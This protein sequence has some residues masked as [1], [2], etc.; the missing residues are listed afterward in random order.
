MDDGRSG[1]RS[2]FCCSAHFCCTLQ[3]VCMP[4]MMNDHKPEEICRDFLRKACSRGSSCKFRH[5][6][7]SEKK[8]EFCRDFQNSYCHRVNCK[9]IH[10]SPEKEEYFWDTGELPQSLDKESSPD[11]DRMLQEREIPLCKDFLSGACKRGV[12]CKYRHRSIGD[13]EY[14]ERLRSIQPYPEARM[15]FACES[16]RETSPFDEYSHDLARRRIATD[17]PYH[18]SRQ[19]RL[20]EYSSANGYYEYAR[21][22]SMRDFE[23]ENIR[24]LRKIEDL[25][26]QVDDL[27]ATNEVLLEQNARLRAVKNDVSAVLLAESHLVRSTSAVTPAQVHLTAATAGAV[28][29][30][31]RVAAAAPPAAQVA[32]ANPTAQVITAELQGMPVSIASAGGLTAASLPSAMTPQ[33]PAHSSVPPSV[34][35]TSSMMTYP[36]PNLRNVAT[37]TVPNV[38][39]VNVA[40]VPTPNRLGP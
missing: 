8:Y 34:C 33:V 2:A 17:L 40:N 31:A 3:D 27:T 30:P 24:L 20:E 5:P 10:C 26:K 37:V 38:A 19:S 1:A 35:V 16:P 6:R 28:P 13:I 15:K 12:K 29:Y 14:E 18:F 4:C 32:T 23:E 11:T 25:R 39:T 21:S 36:L 22:R 7:S 9:Y